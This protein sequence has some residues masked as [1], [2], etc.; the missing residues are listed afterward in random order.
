MSL[1]QREFFNLDEGLDR[2]ELGRQLAA[3]A[4]WDCLT[5]ARRIATRIAITE[6]DCDIDRVQETLA[7]YGFRSADLGNAAGSVFRGE[8]WIFTGQWRESRRVGNHARSIRVWR[9]QR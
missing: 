7:G 6:G 5:L 9:L 3:E 4:N 1:V 8:E 2:K